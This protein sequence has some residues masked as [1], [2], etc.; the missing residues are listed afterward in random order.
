MIRVEIKTN[1]T[2]VLEHQV[3]FLGFL[4]QEC[5]KFYL[6]NPKRIIKAK[7]MIMNSLSFEIAVK[8]TDYLGRLKKL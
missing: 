7:L 6:S 1:H 5:G 4:C 3:F 2:E 8:I